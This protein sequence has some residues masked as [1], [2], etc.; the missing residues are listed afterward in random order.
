MCRSLKPNRF[1]LRFNRWTLCV[2]LWNHF[3]QT[4]LWRSETSPNKQIAKRRKSDCM[5][6]T[7]DMLRDF[8][9]AIFCIQNEYV[10]N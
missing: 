7:N 9:L 3:L 1:I 5:P 2:G 6:Q 10:Q 8:I 4:I